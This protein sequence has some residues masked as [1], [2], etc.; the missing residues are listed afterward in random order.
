M[1]NLL[2]ITDGNIE[3]SGICNFMLQWIK[4]IR[5]SYGFDCQITVYFRKGV[6]DQSMKEEYEAQNVAIVCGEIPDEGSS[7]NA[8]YRKK[9]REDIAS[10]LREQK[11][12]IVH[13]NSSAIGYTSIALR[14][15]KKARVPI[16]ISHAHGRNIDGK[17]KQLYHMLLRSYTRFAATVYAGCSADSGLY[18]FGKA[19]INSSKWHFVP[20]TVDAQKYAYND[21][22]RMACRKALKLSENDLLIGAVGYLEEIKNHTF[23]LD[24]I[25]S[26]KQMGKKATLIIFGEGTLRPV[27]EKKAEEMGIAD[28]VILFGN[29]DQ[30]YKWLSAVDCYVMPSLSEGL[31]IAA[32]EAQ[33]NGL[34]CLLSDGVPHDVDLSKDVYHLATDKGPEPWVKQILQL[35]KKT[36]EERLSGVENVC[37]AGFGKESLPSYVR[38]LYQS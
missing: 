37:K 19:G 14:E 35:P 16:R 32:V 10:I 11:F 26:L 21:D 9:N 4:G 12:D 24:V 5:S 7:L 23:L 3:R 27:L 33:A 38:D 2:M 22:N 25:A 15:S 8:A 18:M 17:I 6:K 13:V 1:S 28:Q 31:P 20:N 30:V 36:K 29:T 34:N